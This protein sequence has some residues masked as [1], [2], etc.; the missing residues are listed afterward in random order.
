[1][2]GWCRRGRAPFVFCFLRVWCG[3]CGGGR[4]GRGVCRWWCGRGAGFGGGS[5]DEAVAD[6]CE[7]LVGEFG[8]EKL[9]IGAGEEVGI[10]AGDG[11]D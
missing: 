6:Q 1:L 9:V 4:G 2:L 10:V 11:G 8:L 7:P 5:E 3:L